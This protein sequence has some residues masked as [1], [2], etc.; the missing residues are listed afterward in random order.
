MFIA[1]SLMSLLVLTF[2]LQF[3]DPKYFDVGLEFLLEKAIQA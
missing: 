2:L 3:P 1:E